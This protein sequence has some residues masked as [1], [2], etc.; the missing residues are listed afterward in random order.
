M[1]NSKDTQPKST[2]VAAV[3]VPAAVVVD[4]PPAAVDQVVEFLLDYRGKLT[5]EQY[6]L[7]GTRVAFPAA[8]AA[9]LVEAG[10][11]ITVDAE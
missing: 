6:F 9:A 8:Q 5:A 1:S 4:Q 7:K 2:P 10:R 11:A 3:V